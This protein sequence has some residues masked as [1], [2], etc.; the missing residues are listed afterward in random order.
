MYIK[1]LAKLKRIKNISYPIN[2]LQSKID[3]IHAFLSHRI[4]RA[5][6]SQLPLPNAYESDWKITSASRV[7]ALLC[8]YIHHFIILQL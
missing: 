4:S 3:L 5:R 2:G 1:R 8:K 6:R 7:M